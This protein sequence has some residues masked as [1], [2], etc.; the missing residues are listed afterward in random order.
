[1]KVLSEVQR[2]TASS[3]TRAGAAFGLVAVMSVM[4]AAVPAMSSPMLM[5]R[6][7]LG[8]DTAFS[9]ARVLN[10]LGSI[11]WWVI[12]IIGAGAA[13]V[14]LRLVLQYGVRYAAAW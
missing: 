4:L 14:A 5:S 13:G 7:G 3:R 6:F 9:I 10:A 8:S 12:L 2:T 1:M 11:P